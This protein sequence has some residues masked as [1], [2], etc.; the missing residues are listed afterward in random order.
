[1][2]ILYEDNH[3]IAVNKPH[4]Q[5]VQADDSGDLSLLDE[6]KIFIKNRDQKPGNVYLGLLHRLDRPV[7]GVVLFAKTSKAASRLSEQFRNHT[8]IKTYIAQVEGIPTDSNGGAIIEGAIT[9][10]LLKD[11]LTNTVAIVSANTPNA[12]LAHLT[13]KVVSTNNNQ[14]KIEI[15]PTTGRSHQIR[16]ALASLKTP[17]VGDL[18]YGAQRPRLDGN[19]SLWATNLTFSHPTTKILITVSSTPK[20]PK[21]LNYED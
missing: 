15:K 20:F 16:V 9:Q 2:E 10:W 1:M 19:I 3:L 13:Y 21:S 6:I 18:K 11:E 12:K 4:G 5:P 17:I 7:S 8:V 14:T